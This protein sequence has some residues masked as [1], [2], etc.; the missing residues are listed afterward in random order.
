MKA[1]RV[2]HVAVVSP[3]P[4]LDGLPLASPR[5]RA[6]AFGL[7]ATIL[8]VPTIIVAML[9]AA[10]ALAIREPAA[11]NALWQR[12]AG[13]SNADRDRIWRE[14]LAV[15]LV[16]YDADGLPPSLALAVEQG[17]LAR[18]GEMIAP[19]DVLVHVSLG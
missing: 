4:E 7:D 2:L 12:S 18:A 16:R 17:D 10:A 1:T 8:F 13:G 15:L 19:D 3:H 14:Q 5:Q 9:A 11:F 6:V